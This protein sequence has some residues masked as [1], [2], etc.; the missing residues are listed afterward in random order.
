MENNNQMCQ[1]KL[2]NTTIT[3]KE[4]QYLKN[5]PTLWK[6]KN[7]PFDERERIVNINYFF[8]E[9]PRPSSI[10]EP[11]GFPGRADALKTTVTIPKFLFNNNPFLEHDPNINFL[12]KEL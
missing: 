9:E 8:I 11:D 6:G 1:Y 10:N 3:Y 7:I 12:K 5:H 4:W 2:D